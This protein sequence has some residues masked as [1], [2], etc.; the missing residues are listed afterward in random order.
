V[1]VTTARRRRT[2]RDTAAAV[3]VIA[4]VLGAGC[5]S[6]QQ[7][8][9]LARSQT[10][11]VAFVNDG[12]TLRLRD[13]R[14]IRLVQIDAP[15]RESECYGRA[16]GAVLARLAPPGTR[17]TLEPDAGLD[18]HDRY[19]RL[20]RYVSVGATELNLELVARG[21]AA[22]YFYK[23][24]RGREAGALL[25]AA[26]DARSARLGLWGACPGAKLQPRLG[27]LTGRG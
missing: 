23:G 14:R 7:A 1:P 10:G 18:E 9:P 17:V 24:E 16:A 2:A 13:G 12:D 26:E 6:T 5:G 25:R 3:S 15:E 4:L 11:V 27:S 8:A 22:P 20:L 19:G 21:A